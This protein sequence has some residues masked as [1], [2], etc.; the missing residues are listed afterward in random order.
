MIQGLTHANTAKLN[1]SPCFGLYL[2]KAK[3]K[4][5][6]PAL[7]SSLLNQVN[8]ATVTISSCVAA[9]SS[10]I[11]AV[12]N[13]AES[14][15]EFNS[16]ALSSATVVLP[17]KAVTS[18]ADA[19]ASN[20][21]YDAIAS[22]VKAS[23]SP[24]TTGASM[25]P[26]GTSVTPVNGIDASEATA[27]ALTSLTP[28]DMT[29]SL[30]SLT[31]HSHLCSVQDTEDETDKDQE[32][33][34]LPHAMRFCALCNI[35]SKKSLKNAVHDLAPPAVT[36]SAMTS[37]KLHHI[38][39]KEH[40]IP[41]SEVKAQQM[42]NSLTSAYSMRSNADDES[43]PLQ[44]NFISHVGSLFYKN[45]IARPKEDAMTVSSDKIHDFK[46]HHIAKLQ[47]DAP[48]VRKAILLR[49]RTLLDI[50]TKNDLKHQNLPNQ[51]SAMTIG[52]CHSSALI[53]SNEKLLSRRKL[54]Y[55]NKRRAYKKE[56]EEQIKLLE[57]LNNLHPKTLEQSWGKAHDKHALEAS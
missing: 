40:A 36:P 31:N 51:N 3:V 33:D 53:S 16:A 32:S 14:T 9:I 1:L 19:S 4:A 5:I 34:A 28:N 15:S 18:P 35:T 43:Y 20:T 6:M 56:R 42:T 12:S 8:A 44:L 11:A 49:H 39:S 7:N 37:H 22:P 2:E 50:V 17:A 54:K 23:S 46:Q 30:S 24:E 10:S 38:R 26:E 57:R 45:K 21:T 25:S 55:D 29:M 41:F 47:E 13:S 52:D 48:L 27:S